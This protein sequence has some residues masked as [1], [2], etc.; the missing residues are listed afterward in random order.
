M[1]KMVKSASTNPRSKMGIARTP[2]AKDETT[3][4]AASHC[5]HTHTHTRQDS[6]ELRGASLSSTHHCA[7]LHHA[8][9]RPLIL[10]DPLDA[11]LLDAKSAGE[12]LQFEVEAVSGDERL[13]VDTARLVRDNA[14]P[15]FLACSCVLDIV[16]VLFVAR[17]GWQGKDIARL[18]SVFQYPRVAVVAAEGGTTRVSSKLQD[19]GKTKEA[20]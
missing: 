12:A 19:K 15:M 17:H 7:D 16:V 13:A 11:A 2:M 14:A 8:L 5:A 9:V 1:K 3:I 18:Q 4:L 20:G 10:R 6:R